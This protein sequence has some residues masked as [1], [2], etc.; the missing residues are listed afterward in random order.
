MIF[1]GW[2]PAGPASL[3]KAGRAFAPGSAGHRFSMLPD[4]PMRRVSSV[5]LGIAAIF[6]LTGAAVFRLLRHGLPEP[7]ELA[8]SQP[9]RDAE[10]FRSAAGQIQS[11]YREAIMHARNPG[12]VTLPAW[13]A[14][15]TSAGPDSQ[16][17]RGRRFRG[18]T[19]N[20]TAAPTSL[21]LTRPLP[22]ATRRS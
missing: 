9:G 3:N 15:M 16:P 18:R 7:S 8:R 14:T 19:R 17:I 12:G 5:I 10:P 22:P 6:D 20:P 21:P 1:N 4:R 2:I 11:A 13:P